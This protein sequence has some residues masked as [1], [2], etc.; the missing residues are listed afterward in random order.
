LRID[1]LSKHFG[2][3]PDRRRQG[4]HWHPVPY[5]PPTAVVAVIGSVAALATATVMAS[6]RA[7]TERRG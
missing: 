7:V 2:R 1:H 5:I 4:D 6:L 3:H